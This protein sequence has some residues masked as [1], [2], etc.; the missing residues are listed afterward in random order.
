[1]KHAGIQVAPAHIHKYVYNSF[2]NKYMNFNVSGMI[3]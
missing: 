3:P 2:M 1:M